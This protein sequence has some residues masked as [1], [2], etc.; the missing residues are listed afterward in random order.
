MV[1]HSITSSAR[2]G[3]DGGTV[4]SLTINS[5]FVGNCTGR[6]AVE[7]TATALIA[8]F[9]QQEPFAKGRFRYS[10]ADGSLPA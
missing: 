2:V 6:S 5:Y 10:L 8:R 7:T 4:R 9:A 1:N 3:S